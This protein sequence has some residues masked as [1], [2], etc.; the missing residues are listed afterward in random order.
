MAVFS[1]VPRAFAAVELPARRSVAS[2]GWIHHHQRRVLNTST[3]LESS[4]GI[5]PAACLSHLAHLSTGTRA[6]ASLPRLNTLDC[7]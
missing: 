7:L 5:A 4:R 3:S 6:R 1:T 2:V